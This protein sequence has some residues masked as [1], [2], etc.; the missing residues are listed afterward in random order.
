MLHGSRE[1]LPPLDGAT[2]HFSTFSKGTRAATGPVLSACL[3]RVCLSRVGPAC[4][5][6]IAATEA[7]FPGVL[8]SGCR[9][10]MA[11]QTQALTV[12]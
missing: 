11:L 2:K 6:L 10:C 12:R 9:P 7:V 4:W 8:F 3:L 5:G 1:T